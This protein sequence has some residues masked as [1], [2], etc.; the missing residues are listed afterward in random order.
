MLKIGEFSQ[1]GQVSIRMLRHYDEIG[2]LKPIQTDHFTGYRY[3]T[4]EQLTQLHRILA[5]KDLG[6]SLEQITEFQNQNL[7]L[8][9]M[10]DLLYQKQ[11]EV[12]QQIQ[13]E[14]IRLARIEAR[15]RQIEKE[16]QLPN[17][18][19]FIKSVPVQQV[20][21]IRQTVPTVD[22]MKDYRCEMYKT[23]YQFLQNQRIPLSEPEFAIYHHLEY[24]EE[25]IDMELGVAI[26]RLGTPTETIG[27]Y[28]LPAIHCASVVHVGS[29]WEIGLALTALFSWIN[30]HKYQSIGAIREIHLFGSELKMHDPLNVTLEFQVA[31]LDSHIM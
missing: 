19:V 28:E 24:I 27:F 6:F 23:L 12:E 26:S 13:T 31:V 9:T 4:L 11:V 21:T 22:G 29:F 8:D 5:L 18:E 25:N 16:G 10:R 7:S 17:Y 14:R 15:L 30:L 3:Y 1:I 2:L 20:A